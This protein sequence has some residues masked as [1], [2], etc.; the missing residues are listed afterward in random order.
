[1]FTSNVNS[2]TLNSWPEMVYNPNF[3]TN[4]FCYKN[5]SFSF[6]R[7]WFWLEFILDACI[8]CS[9]F[10]A[11]ATLCYS[12]VM[13]IKLNWII[14][15]DHMDYHNFFNVWFLKHIWR[16]VYIW[17]KSVLAERERER[18]SATTQFYLKLHISAL[19]VGWNKNRCEN[20]SILIDY[21]RQ[22]F[23]GWSFQ[24][25]LLQNKQIWFPI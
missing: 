18:E 6:R 14:N 15:W 17:G 24:R 20:T 19:K 8:T 9:L 2:W 25:R 22:A 21:L 16:T 1:M 3:N 12:I 13:P 4:N 7:H 23:P 5:L 10:I 11:L